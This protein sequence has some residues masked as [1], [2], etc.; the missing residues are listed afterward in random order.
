MIFHNI[1]EWGSLANVGLK[2]SVANAAKKARNDR[3]E[4]F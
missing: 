3:G 1:Q 2:T 4:I